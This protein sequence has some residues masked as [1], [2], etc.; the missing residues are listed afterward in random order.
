MPKRT[1]ERPEKKILSA[2]L[3]SA[4]GGGLVCIAALCLCAKLIVVSQPS[5]WWAVPIAA[6][7]VMLGSFVGGYLLARRLGQNG[8]FCGLCSGLFFFLVFALAAVCSGCY[9]YTAFAAIKCVCYAL[10]G[11]LGGYLGILSCERAG[12]KAH[13]SR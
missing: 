11:A 3:L 2:I 13:V 8:L 5:A 4:C 10:S 12:R 1:S 6:V 7:A 9:E